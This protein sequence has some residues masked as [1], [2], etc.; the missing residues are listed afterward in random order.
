MIYHKEKPILIVEAWCSGFDALQLL[1]S[2]NGTVKIKTAHSAC[3]TSNVSDVGIA[4]LL[5]F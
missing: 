5:S 4:Q 1:N 3:D 2:T